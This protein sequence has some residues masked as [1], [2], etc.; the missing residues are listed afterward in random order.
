MGLILSVNEQKQQ[1]E[2]SQPP[3]TLDDI[4]RRKNDLIF[5]SC[6]C[7]AIATVCIITLIYLYICEDIIRINCAGWTL[8]YSHT[9]PHCIE[10]RDNIPP[11]L[12]FAMSKVNCAASNVQC[13]PEIKTVPTWLNRYTKQTWDGRGVFRK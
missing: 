8:Y 4:Q 1:V 3:P 10:L 6:I 9:C 12:W 2:H 13:P 5:K 11:Y 7:A